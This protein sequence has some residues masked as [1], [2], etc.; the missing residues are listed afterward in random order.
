VADDKVGGKA[1]GDEIGSNVLANVPDINDFVGGLS[2]VP[3]PDG[4]V[5]VEFPHLLR[6]MENIQF[7]T[8]Y[9]EHFYYL[10]LLA[11]EKVF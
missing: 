2:A 4:V 3:K 5:S 6:L 9:Q 8:V 7:D 10:S 1:A 11:V